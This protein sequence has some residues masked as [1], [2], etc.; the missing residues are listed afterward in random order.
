MDIPGS[1][2]EREHLGRDRPIVTS[3]A[4]YTPGK[5]CGIACSQGLH[6]D[7]G[8][9]FGVGRGPKPISNFPGSHTLFR[10]LITETGRMGKISPDE[11]T[12]NLLDHAKRL[13]RVTIKTAPGTDVS[14]VK[15]VL[16]NV[17]SVRTARNRDIEIV[18]SSPD[19]RTL[20]EMQQAGLN[21]D[22][23]QQTL[24]QTDPFQVKQLIRHLLKTQGLVDGAEVSYPLPLKGYLGNK[25]S[26]PATTEAAQILADTGHDSHLAPAF[27]Q[28]EV[29]DAVAAIGFANFALHAREN[30]H[31]V[32][33]FYVDGD[34]RHFNFDIQ[35]THLLG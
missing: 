15:D 25:G 1:N 28:Q 20:K 34:P 19:A 6:M 13:S 9:E 10:P 33:G 32:R 12:T 23:W 2:R 7:K 18:I 22:T 27:T 30:P 29:A 4:A 26:Y 16:E 8:I 5:I 14:A 3:L 31:R 35:A 21:A 11:L 24:R 17:S